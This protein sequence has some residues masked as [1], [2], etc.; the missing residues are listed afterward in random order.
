MRERGK[1][2]GEPIPKLIRQIFGLGMA[3][4]LIL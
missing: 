1:S 4:R 2:H 3:M